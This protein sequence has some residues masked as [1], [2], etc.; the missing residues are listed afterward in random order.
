MCNYY[1]RAGLAFGHSA[2]GF[3]EFVD[4]RAGIEALRSL[5]QNPVNDPAS[6]GADHISVSKLYEAFSLMIKAVPQGHSESTSGRLYI[7]NAI[8]FI[9]RNFSE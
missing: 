1:K 5:A 6:F 7:K 4:S 3:G 9:Q 2:A 8:K